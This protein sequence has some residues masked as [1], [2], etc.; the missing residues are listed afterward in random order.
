MAMVIALF[1]ASL[2]LTVITAILLSAAMRTPDFSPPVRE[3]PHPI[4]PPRFFAEGIP[5]SVHAAAASDMPVN[6]LVLK[7]ERHVRLERA[8]AESFHLSPTAQTLH[9]QAGSPLV[10]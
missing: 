4:G 1:A 6:V 2:V 8:A 9:M 5:G 10:H 7:I 3:N